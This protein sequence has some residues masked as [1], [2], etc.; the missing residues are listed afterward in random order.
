MSLSRIFDV[1]LL[2]GTSEEA[3]QNCHCRDMH[4]SQM[5]V[6]ETPSPEVM[7]AKRNRRHNLARQATA[8]AQKAKSKQVPIGSH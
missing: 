2:W 5:T 8:G 7:A 6:P 3:S 1:A 4:A